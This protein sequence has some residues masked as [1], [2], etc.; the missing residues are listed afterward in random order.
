M[1]GSQ[2]FHVTVT[3]KGG[4]A[5]LPHTTVDSIVVASHLVV[6]LQTIVSR[7][8]NRNNFHIVKFVKLCA[9]EYKRSFS[10]K[11]AKRLRGY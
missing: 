11:M 8:V 1:A 4:H 5:G 7:S 9:H 2:N 3:G 10:T 6:A